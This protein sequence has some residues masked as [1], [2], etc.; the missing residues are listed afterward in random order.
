MFRCVNLAVLMNAIFCKNSTRCLSPRVSLSFVPLFKPHFRRYSSA[1]IL[2]TQVES[3]SYNDDYDDDLSNEIEISLNEIEE[4]LEKENITH[5][6]KTAAK[7][8]FQISNFRDGQQGVLEYIWGRL[9][10]DLK[11][12]VVIN[13]PCGSGKSLLF[14]LPAYLLTHRNKILE[15][16]DVE[17]R[18]PLK[19]PVCLVLV[20][21][22]AIMKDQVDKLQALNLYGYDF[23]VCCLHSDLLPKESQEVQAKIVNGKVDM[24]FMA[25]ERLDT[26]AARFR[27]QLQKSNSFIHTIVIDE[28]HC[29]D[30]ASY[31]P[32]YNSISIGNIIEEFEPSALIRLTGTPM[33]QKILKTD[34]YTNLEAVIENSCGEKKVFQSQ[35]GVKYNNIELSMYKHY[36]EEDKMETILNLDPETE[37]PCIVYV[38]TTKSA[39]LY[40]NQ[41]R[42]LLESN[43][44]VG[45]LDIE[46][47]CYHG[48]MK[49]RDKTDA[50]N[51]FVNNKY[52]ILFATKA[53]GMGVDK[54]DIRTVI[55]W[56]TPQTVED[57]VQEIGRV[58]RDGSPSKAILYYSKYDD[59][60][61]RNVFLPSGK[62]SHA[63]IQSI[64]TVLRKNKPNDE[65]WGEKELFENV[66]LRRS[67]LLETEPDNFDPEEH[68]EIFSKTSLEHHLKLLKKW[69]YVDY[70][71]IK[72]HLHI[73]LDQ[74][75]HGYRSN[76][77][78]FFIR[79][80]YLPREAEIQKNKWINLKPLDE[81]VDE[82]NGDKERHQILEK[83][84]AE[85]KGERSDYISL[86]DSIQSLERD[87]DKV[88]LQDILSSLQNK[89]AIQFEF[90][91]Q[92]HDL[93]LNDD[94]VTAFEECDEM[95]D[96]D[97]ILNN[98]ILTA[99]EDGWD[100]FKKIIH[101]FAVEPIEI[102]RN[103]RHEIWK[104]FEEYHVKNRSDKI[105]IKNRS[106][107]IWK[108][109][110]EYFKQ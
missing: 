52:A 102:E 60:L 21:L 64:I 86:T 27:E 96:S 65:H 26:W 38:N 94:I 80:Q 103:K 8:K 59:F 20:P 17:R 37:L 23:K 7:E 41:C 42:G 109:I 11:A 32:T 97:I 28:A 72:K 35:T 91:V 19:K 101:K 85:R 22:I 93:R 53:F 84:K 31:R 76:S 107:K 13:L 106:D 90:E 46:I 104:E 88:M 108:E 12:N 63:T 62:V 58:G 5:E 45:D 83:W 79:N 40:A 36:K 74:E 77:W 44:D 48:A 18:G 82:L 68:D 89:N 16:S 33:T 10:R 105:R 3:F 6:F 55:H 50:Q 4:K 47:K 95:K 57:Y 71:D 1:N 51:W 34:E 9:R 87:L 14:Q 39:E 61:I 67:E 92:H 25:P 69:G 110:E 70:K 30:T 29:I 15:N 24:I 73:R 54:K 98:K 66:K 43:Q 2:G 81:W 78:N 75:S 49:S 99:K 100:E 56:N